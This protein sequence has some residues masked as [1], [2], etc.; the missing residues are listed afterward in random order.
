MFDPIL[1][2]LDWLGFYPFS[3]WSRLDFEPIQAEI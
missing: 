3:G 2:S 1:G